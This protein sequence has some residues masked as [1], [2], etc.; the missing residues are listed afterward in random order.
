MERDDDRRRLFTF[1]EHCRMESN[2]FDSQNL[3]FD[4][5]APPAHDYIIQKKF[6]KIDS[7]IIIQ[8]FM[9]GYSEF[10]LFFPVKSI[11]HFCY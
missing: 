11:I 1:G 5:L 9:N 4:N 6:F 10:I 3:L 8:Y 2:N 7:V